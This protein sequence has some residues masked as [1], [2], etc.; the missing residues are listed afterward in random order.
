MVPPFEVLGVEELL[1]LVEPE[2]PLDD[3]DDDEPLLPLVEVTVLPEPLPLEPPMLVPC[4]P[5]PPVEL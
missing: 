2:L 3:D 5:E 4:E 1:A